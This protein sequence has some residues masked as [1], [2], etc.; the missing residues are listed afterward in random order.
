MPTNI[1]SFS[2][3]R[4]RFHD[5]VFLKKITMFS[6]LDWV[7][8]VNVVEHMQEIDLPAGKSVKNNDNIYIVKKGSIEMEKKNGKIVKMGERNV[9]GNLLMYERGA[10][11]SVTAFRDAVLLSID[12]EV[13]LGLIS[14]R[15]K[16]FHQL[17]P[18]MGDIFRTKF[19]KDYTSIREII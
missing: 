10:T 7:T 16:Q 17:A 6:D 13:L 15:I 2:I 8:V 4:I 14:S 19:E 3:G 9:F 12:R 11:E 18:N 5:I 1:D